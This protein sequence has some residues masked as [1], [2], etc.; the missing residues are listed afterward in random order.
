MDSKEKWSIVDSVTL[1]EISRVD[2]LEFQRLPNDSPGVEQL[3]SE[4]RWKRATAD[5]N[6]GKQR[7]TSR[8]TMGDRSFQELTGDE[9]AVHGQLE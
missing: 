1:A 7:S 9:I 6:L 5:E 2:E 4:N 3:L 8:P